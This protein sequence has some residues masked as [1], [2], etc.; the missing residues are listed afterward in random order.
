MN[1]LSLPGTLLVVTLLLSACDLTSLTEGFLPAQG[2]L[3]IVLDGLPPEG[4]ANVEIRGPDAY[5][6]TID[7]QT[8]LSELAVGA[9]QVVANPV[10]VDGTTY[11]PAEQVKDVDVVKDVVGQVTIRYSASPGRR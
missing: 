6:R 2:S 5:R 4:E 11:A 10:E 1:R 8:T 7:F 3:H 9:Y